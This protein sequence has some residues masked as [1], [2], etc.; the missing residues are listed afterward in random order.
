MIK[1]EECISKRIATKICNNKG[2][3]DEDIISKEMDKVDIAIGFGI[4]GVL[5]LATGYSTFESYKIQQSYDYLKN[6]TKSYETDYKEM[7]LN[8]KD[9]NSIDFANYIVSS[10]SPDLALYTMC[11]TL[12]D[13]YP[14]LVY[15]TMEYLEYDYNGST[16]YD[17]TYDNYIKLNDFSS[18]DEYEDSIK[19][20]IYNDKKHDREIELDNLNVRVK[21]LTLENNGN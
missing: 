14:K 13:D 7:L 10:D 3:T 4:V 1:N 6:A 2:I 16:I 15:D 19:K 17:M 18:F 5:L 21:K 20:E 12:K 9:I 8:K 11:E